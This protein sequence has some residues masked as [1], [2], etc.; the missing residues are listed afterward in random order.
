MNGRIGFVSGFGQWK[1]MVNNCSFKG[2]QSKIS[3]ILDICTPL[4]HT[5]IHA[6]IPI[7]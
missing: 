5:H 6:Y 1:F 7:E 3:Y 2:L 4:P